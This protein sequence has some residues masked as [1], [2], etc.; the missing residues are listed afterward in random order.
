MN[1]ELGYVSFGTID[2]ATGK[3]DNKVISLGDSGY[4]ICTFEKTIRNG[5]GYDFAI[6]ENAFVDSFLE[7]AFV[8]VSSDSIHWVRFPALSLTPT[9]EQIGPFGYINHNNIFNLAGKCK[10]YYGTLFDISDLP[11]YPFLNKNNIKYIKVIDVIGCIN[12][13]Y[14]QTDYYGNIIND[15]YPTAYETGGFDLD[16]IGIINYSDNDDTN[17][18]LY[19]ENK[20]KISFNIELNVKIFNTKGQIIL[21]QNKTKEC[22]LSRLYKGIYLLQL[23]NEKIFITKKICIK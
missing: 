11:D 8:E 14:S 4:V 5:E 16:A 1:K 23:Y 3:A 10:A 7:L 19:D 15:P 21:E 18:Y 12:C 20:K 9:Q 6:F 2:N 17:I 13:L 22:D